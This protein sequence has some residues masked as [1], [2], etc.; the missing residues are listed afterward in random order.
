ML[1][2]RLELLSNGKQLRVA[3]CGEGQPVVLL[4]GYPDN[5]QIW[6][7]LAPR[8][9][10]RFALVAPDWPG[11][12]YSQ[13]WPGGA[14]PSD[15]AERLLT[16][17][18]LWQLPQVDLLAMDMGGPAALAFAARNPSR[19]RRLVVMNSL[20][21]ASAPT[22]WEIRCLRRLGLNRLLLRLLPGIVFRRAQAR[23]LPRHLRLSRELRA[24]F[25]EAFH[26]P[27]VRTF[28]SRMCADY[29]QQLPR[30]PDLYCQVTC[31]VLVLWGG[32]DRH[33]PPVH[34][35]LLHKLIPR[36]HLEVLPQAEHWMAWYRAE[37]VASRV[38]R[39]LEAC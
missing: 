14:A 20:L 37:D 3:R 10:S 36:S 1:P 38:S 17:L 25:W 7:E 34:G 13:P 15:M 18:D 19:T 28:I 21:F 5:L 32:R 27:S 31:P 29:Q 39:F 6:H 22:S 26:R 23:C 9:A 12:G 35:E 4:H 33:F 30:L 8:L 24:D 2:A 11:M 16:L